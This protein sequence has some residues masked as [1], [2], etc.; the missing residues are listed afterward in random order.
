MSGVSLQTQAEV[1]QFI[2]KAAEKHV[3]DHPKVTLS[4]RDAIKVLAV[5]GAH[6]A[7]SEGCMNLVGTFDSINERMGRKHSDGSAASLRA[8]VWFLISNSQK[9]AEAVDGQGKG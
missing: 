4:A 5:L 7:G 8:G 9:A 1:D 6:V 3:E 2:A